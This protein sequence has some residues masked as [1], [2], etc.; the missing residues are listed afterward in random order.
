MDVA[1]GRD[2]MVRRRAKRAM[3]AEI[4]ARVKTTLASRVATIDLVGRLFHNVDS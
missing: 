4:N 2:V 3:S 1:R